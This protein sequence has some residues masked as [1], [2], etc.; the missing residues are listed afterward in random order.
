MPQVHS[1]SGDAWP[2]ASTRQGRRR[3]RCRVAQM[4]DS[5]IP[6][7]QTVSALRLWSTMR[8][9]CMHTRHTRQA[10]IGSMKSGT[11]ER[12]GADSSSLEVKPSPSGGEE[13]R[14]G[15]R[16]VERLVEV[17]LDVDLLQLVD[18]PRDALSHLRQLSAHRGQR[19]ERA[20]GGRR[21]RLQ[22]LVDLVRAARKLGRERVEALL[23]LL[24]GLSVGRVE[25]LQ[26]AR[27][28]VRSVADLLGRGLQLG[29]RGRAALD[30]RRGAL[31]RSVP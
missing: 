1:S 14:A 15:L 21:A 18:G 2:G 6:G 3:D 26:R 16:L 8:K 9:S 29:L 5:G 30:A 28:L 20:V 17:A 25:L 4:A 11:V 27:K 10:S 19:G 7:S 24:A 31:D 23:R 12:R 22:G 13:A